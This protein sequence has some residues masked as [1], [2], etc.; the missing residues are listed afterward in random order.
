MNLLQERRAHAR[1]VP[2]VK[3]TIVRDLAKYSD[4]AKMTGLTEDDE[5]CAVPESQ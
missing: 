3:H 4:A 2:N 1:H 5:A